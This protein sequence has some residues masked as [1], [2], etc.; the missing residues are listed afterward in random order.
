MGKS[1]ISMAIFHGKM[2]VHQ[3]VPPMTTR[4][5]NRL[6]N[7]HP[8]LGRLGR[9]RWQLWAWQRSLELIGDG[10][11]CWVL[12]PFFAP[13]KR[14][15]KGKILGHNH[16]IHVI[17]V[18]MVLRLLDRPAFWKWSTQEGRYP[19]DLW[20]LCRFSGQMVTSLAAF[21]SDSN[22]AQSL[23]EHLSFRR[24]HSKIPIFWLILFEDPDQ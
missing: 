10:P 8:Q 13:V 15:G 1:T 9:L 22:F 23:N 18:N 7:H 20:S 19:L 6:L 2:L 24:I 12:P 4:T 17:H 5:Q 11:K 14:H 3:R 21:G 16:V